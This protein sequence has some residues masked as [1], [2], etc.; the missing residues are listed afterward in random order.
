MLETCR[1]SIFIAR[2][3]QLDASLIIVCICYPLLFSCIHVV[4]L[5]AFEKDRVDPKNQK[6]APSAN[7]DGLFRD[8]C[9]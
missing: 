4:V 7:I 6:D 1:R 2:I 8:S 3:N 9:S 5:L